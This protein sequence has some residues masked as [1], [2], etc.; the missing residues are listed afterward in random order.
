MPQKEY[1][2]YSTW[3]CRARSGLQEYLLVASDRM[4]VDLYT[5][6]ADGRWLLTSANRLEDTLDLESVN[7][8]LSLAE[9][10]EKVDLE[11]A[12]A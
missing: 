10:Y 12:R 5:R 4:H 6:Q 7:C 11:G 3:R 2:V 8:R 9:L 1:S